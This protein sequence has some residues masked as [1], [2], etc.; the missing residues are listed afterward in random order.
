MKT[1]QYKITVAIAS[2]IA[3][4]E[5]TGMCNRSTGFPEKK[6]FNGTNLEQKRV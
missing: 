6:T 3:L 2:F 1:N 5:H 4:E